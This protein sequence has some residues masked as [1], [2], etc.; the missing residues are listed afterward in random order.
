MIEL[1]ESLTPPYPIPHSHLLLFLHHCVLHLVA[2]PL[3]FTHSFLLLSP[4]DTGQGPSSSLLPISFFLC[5]SSQCPPLLPHHHNLYLIH[6]LP[7]A[8]LLPNLSLLHAYS[9]PFPRYYSTTH[10]P[11]SIHTL[12][13]PIW[14]LS[15]LTCCPN[16][17]LLSSA[18]SWR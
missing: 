18:Y 8:H 15:C 9:A 2:S 13:C 10:I 11:V 4:S 16:R 5:L 12:A 1:P 3:P 6:H 14:I 17:L 7:F